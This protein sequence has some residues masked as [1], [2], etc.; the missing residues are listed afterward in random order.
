MQR[1]FALNFGLRSEMKFYARMKFCAL[2]PPAKFKASIEH[3]PPSAKLARW[4]FIHAQKAHE[5]AQKFLRA[6]QI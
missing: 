6:A 1:G 2:R 4:E 3:D 5:L